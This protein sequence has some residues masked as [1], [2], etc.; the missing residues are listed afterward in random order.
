MNKRFKCTICDGKG[1]YIE[2]DVR[3]NCHQ[4]NSSGF[5][6]YKQKIQ[7]GDILIEMERLSKYKSKHKWASEVTNIKTKVH[8]Y[9]LDVFGSSYKLVLNKTI[10]NLKKL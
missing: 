6:N 8:H 2:D 5:V 3:S 4:C 10:K 1:F 7:K 9:E